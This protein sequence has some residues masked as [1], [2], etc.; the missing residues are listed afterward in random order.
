MAP[1]TST[2]LRLTMPPI[3][4][5]IRNADDAR[6]VVHRA[7]QALAEGQ[8][9]ALPTETVYGLAAS[10]CRADAVDRLMEVKGRPANQPF[11]LA[12]KSAEEAP[13]FVPDMSPLA[14]RLARRCW[15]GPVT[16]VVDN[17][18]NEGLTKQLPREVCEIITPNGMIGLRVPANTM[19]QD[20]L[21]MLS[22]PI[23]LTSANRS[24]MPDSTTA[25]Q[26][27]EAFDGEIAMVLDDGPCRY[28]QPS[29]VV[30][31][32][33][34]HFEMLREGV[35]GETTLRRLAGV[36]VL[37]V[38]TGNTC[39]SPMAESLMRQTLAKCLKCD[40]GKLD[41]HGFSVISAG[42]AAAPGCPPATEAVQ[43]MRE[44]GI[45]LSRHE[46]QPLTDRLVRD[47]DVIVAMTQSHMQSITDRWPQAAD[48]TCLLLPDRT[49][50]P[51]PLGQPVGAYRH[52]AAQIA[53]AVKHH[54]GR[55]REQGLE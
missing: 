24:G 37:F 7:V 35:V 39:R 27:V 53:E 20:V 52:C 45:D 44:H 12:I 46:A 51:D 9:I 41:E 6:D 25:Q 55:I 18:H 11:T 47:A 5:D 30:K 32:K 21:R 28:G 3:V 1:I 40:P 23:V 38:C 36:V 34:N 29:S 13:D 26:V 10:A 4:I 33:S 16:L 2:P 48:R 22:G 50:L 17:Q 8:I 49:D 15:P 42:I 54:L 19:S 43:V 14:Q 31:V